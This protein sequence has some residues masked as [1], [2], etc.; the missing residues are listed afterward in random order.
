MG[1]GVWSE[2]RQSVLLSSREEGKRREGSLPLPLHLLRLKNVASESLV[3]H[4]HLLPTVWAEEHAAQQC[5]SAVPWVC[6]QESK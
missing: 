5:C 4:L 2:A 6:P 3:L 1:Q